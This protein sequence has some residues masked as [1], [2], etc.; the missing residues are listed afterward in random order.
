VRRAAVCG[1]ILLVFPPSDLSAQPLQIGIIDFYGLHRVSVDEARRALTFHEGDTISFDAEPPRYLE[2]SVTRLEAQPEV[3]RA[4]TEIVCCDEGRVIVFVGIEER[5]AP[6]TRFRKA[7][8][9]AERLA[10]DVVEVGEEFSNALMA[11]VQRGHAGEDDSAGH[12]LAH[13]A[14]ARAAQ[15][16]FLVFA[17]RDLPTLRRVVRD[18]S[19]A[20]HR[21][22]AAQVL[23]YVTDKQA[24]VDDLVR[25]MRDPA[26]PVRNNAMRALLVFAK[27]KRARVPAEPFLVLLGSPV[28]TDRNKSSWALEALT[29]D[30]D[31]KLLARLHK[32]ALG[33]LVEMARWTST[34]HAKA[35]FLIL[36]R[37]AGYSDEAA[38]AAW[39]RGEREVVIRAAVA[40][41]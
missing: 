28:W 11:A 16:R 40:Q 24:V 9:G 13:D 32:Q 4:R 21:A 2:E 1:A 33:P 7:P 19:D 27:A 23:G 37:V 20:D 34:G 25:A 8:R 15:E 10:T 14:T 22:L 29:Q 26:E 35:G 38:S 31:P 3:E 5:G 6:V 17:E 12:A 30:R 39:D 41:R 36:G 18:S